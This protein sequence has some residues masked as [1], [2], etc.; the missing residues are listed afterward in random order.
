[1]TFIIRNLKIRIGDVFKTGE[2]NQSDPLSIGS[3]K[4]VI[5]DHCSLLMG[6]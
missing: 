5:I 4:Q 1:M 3:S 2:V 6:D